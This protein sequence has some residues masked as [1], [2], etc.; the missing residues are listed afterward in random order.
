[1]ETTARRLRASWF[2]AC[3]RFTRFGT[4]IVERRAV[5]ENYDSDKIGLPD[6]E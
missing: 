1:V 6:S 3:L 5:E 2:W 4:V